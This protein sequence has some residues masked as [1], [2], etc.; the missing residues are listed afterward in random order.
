MEEDI[1]IETI[2]QG[3]K[4]CPKC[5]HFMNPVEVLYSGGKLCP[6]C[7]NAQY[8]YHAKRGMAG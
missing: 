3:S 1:N 4:L 2:Y 8:E 6:S 7:R 5:G